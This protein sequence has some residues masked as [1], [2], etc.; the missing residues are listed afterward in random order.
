MLVRSYTGC[1]LAREWVTH[2]VSHLPRLLN[3]LSDV[4]HA[5]QHVSTRGSQSAHVLHI[6]ECVHQRGKGLVQGLHC[7]DL[8][9][10]RDVS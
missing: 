4:P 1:T 8:S 9:L 2:R 5:V 6:C 10:L 7:G 3:Q